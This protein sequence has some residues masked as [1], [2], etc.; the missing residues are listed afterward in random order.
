[1]KRLSCII[2]N[3]NTANLTR[4]A[5]AAF[6]AAVE[7]SEARVI[8]IDNG[9]TEAFLPPE[10][11]RV[12]FIRN[13]RNLGFAAAVN[14]GLR[15]S[16]GDDVLLLNSDVILSQTAL[17]AMRQYAAAEPSVGIIGP[18][19]TFPDGTFQESAGWFPSLAGEFWRFSKLGRIFRAGMLVY[20]ENF[21]PETFSKAIPVDWVSGGCMLIS[22]QAL[23]RLGP[24]DENF[25]FSVEDIDYCRRA[26]EAG[27]KVAY[28][29]F[30][31]VIHH[32]GFSS[33]GHSSVFSARQEKK[34]MAY[35]LKKHGYGLV[36]RGASRTLYEMKIAAL[37]LRDIMKGKV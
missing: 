26:S 2:L 27:F 30:V 34:S 15:L 24:L 9:S 19:M 3:F 4:Q 10:D 22:G 1:M 35:F 33:G 16:A 28:L 11:E 7:G 25:F 20:P 32:H 36:L 14:Q 18:G 23:E 6:L 37:Q 12:I 21:T 17:T 8:L 13:P 29:P 5:V 31:S